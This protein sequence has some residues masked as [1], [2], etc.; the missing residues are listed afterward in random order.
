MTPPPLPLPRWPRRPGLVCRDAVEL[1]TAYLEG[2]LGRRD[3]ARLEAHL[4]ACSHCHAYVEQIRVTVRALRRVE[5]AELGPQ[6]VHDLVE[7]YRR[8]QAG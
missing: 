6:A 2:T 5:P 7:L 4:A 3:R 1:V 8:W